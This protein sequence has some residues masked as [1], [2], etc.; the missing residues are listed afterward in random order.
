MTPSSAGSNASAP[1][2]ARGLERDEVRLL[3]ASGS[4]VTDTVFHELPAFRTAWNALVGIPLLLP[5]F[6]YEGVHTDHHRQRSYGTPRDPEYVPFGR[7]PPVVMASYALGSAF[8]PF[9][10]AFRFGVLAPLS[11]LV[12]PLR[13]CS[14][15]AS[16]APCP[17]APS[18]VTRCT[19]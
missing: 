5:S 19:R 7:R 16:W 14:S 12:P 6:L 3:V 13:S 17:A 11:W 18:P 15:P 2:E 4:G 8:L 10:V 9:A 1:A